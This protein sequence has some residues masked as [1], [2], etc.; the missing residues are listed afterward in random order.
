MTDDVSGLYSLGG[1]LGFGL[2]LLTGSA[3]TFVRKT[4]QAGIAWTLNYVPIHTGL[5][6]SY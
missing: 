6:S 1:F 3:L 2:S 5:P 4:G